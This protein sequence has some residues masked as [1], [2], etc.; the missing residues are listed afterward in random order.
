MVARGWFTSQS[1]LEAAVKRLC[2]VNKEGRHTG[3]RGE[4]VFPTDFEEVERES[5][6]SDGALIPLTQ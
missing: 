2:A 3:R 5:D 4:Y 1:G 6:P